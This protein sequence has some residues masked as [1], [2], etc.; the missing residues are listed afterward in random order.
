VINIT[1]SKEDLWEAEESA[2]S[3]SIDVSFTPEENGG[4]NAGLQQSTLAYSFGGHLE[5]KHIRIACGDSQ[6][7][8]LSGTLLANPIKLAKRVRDVRKKRSGVTYMDSSLVRGPN[9]I[10]IGR[11]HC[12]EAVAYVSHLTVWLFLHEYLL[13][14]RR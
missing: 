7:G 2:S 12:T 14:V 10:T 6:F 4:K 11:N 3:L 9:I 13:A 1:N 5:V 8:V